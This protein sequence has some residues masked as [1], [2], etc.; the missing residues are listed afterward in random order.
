MSNQNMADPE[1]GLVCGRAA[2]A[3]TGVP[4]FASFVLRY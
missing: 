1:D 4:V 2:G 3:G